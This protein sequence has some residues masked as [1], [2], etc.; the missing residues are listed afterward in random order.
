MMFISLFRPRE[1][2]FNGLTQIHINFKQTA[3][4]QPQLSSVQQ[5]PW[6]E[7]ASARQGMHGDR[8][9]LSRPL[10]TIGLASCK[11]LFS[12]W[13][14]FTARE[15]INKYHR[16]LQSWTT[17][18]RYQGS[19]YSAGMFW[20]LPFILFMP[21]EKTNNKNRIPHLETFTSPCSEILI[22]QREILVY[23]QIP[24]EILKVFLVPM[25]HI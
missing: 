2:S 12:A 10:S 17:S 19:I 5:K 24:L 22:H 4:I 8:Q 9:P 23:T 6:T 21:L 13:V 15:T 16:L 7:L 20:S 11:S 3:L 1:Y 18:L 25:P 14:K